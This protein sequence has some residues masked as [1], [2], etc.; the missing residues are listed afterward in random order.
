M[1]YSKLL[2]LLVG[3]GAPETM[4]HNVQLFVNGLV[5]NLAIYGIHGDIVG[6]CNLSHDRGT[7]QEKVYQV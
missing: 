2:D 4:P 1:F 6:L 5:E 3:F 7:Y